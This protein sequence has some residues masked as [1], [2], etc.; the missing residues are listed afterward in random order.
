MALK[1]K[2]EKKAFPFI[3][4]A[5][6]FLLSDKI[7]LKKA[8]EDREVHRK[9]GQEQRKQENERNVQ[10]YGMIAQM[11]SF[12]PLSFIIGVYLILPFLMES[13]VQLSEFLQ[14]MQT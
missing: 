14:Q 13:M 9:N 12:F 4:I 5:D 7:G 3:S 6:G 10:K 8:F 11:I 2:S 1:T